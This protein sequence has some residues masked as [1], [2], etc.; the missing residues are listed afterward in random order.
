MIRWLKPPVGLA[1]LA[2][3]VALV[4]WSGVAIV[5]AATHAGGGIALNNLG[6]LVLGL[7]SLGASADCFGWMPP[8]RDD[9]KEPIAMSLWADR[10]EIERAG[11]IDQAPRGS[12]KADPSKE[13]IYLGSF[14]DQQGALELRYHGGKSLM[15]FGTPGANKSAGLVAPSISALRRSEAIIDV[16]GE[17]YNITYRQR[18]LMGTVLRLDPFGICDDAGGERFHWNPILQVDPE[19][20]D[21]ASAAYCIADAM[22]DKGSGG[23]NS[24]FFENSALNL[25]AVAVM[26]ERYTKGDKASLRNVRAMIA[27]PNRYDNNKQLVGGFLYTLKQMAE[28]EHPAIR[29]AGAR[30]Y[31]RLT[32]QNS[33]ATSAQ[34]VIDTFMTST[35]F[36]DDPRI[37]ADMWQGEAIDFAKLHEEI[38]TIYLV[39]PPHQLAAQAKWL[40]L[41]VNLALAELYRNPPS[42][43]TL[44]SVLFLLDEFGNLGSLSEI[45]TALNLS[46]GYRIQLWLFLQ[47]L[48][49]LKGNYKDKWG[50]FF[51]GAGAITSFRTGDM[52]TAEQLA[53]FYGNKEQVVPTQTET[54][55]SDTPHAIP[56]IRP[57]DINRLGQGEMI[58]MI[59]P[60]KMPIKGI[61]PVYPQTRFNEG[62]DPNPYYHG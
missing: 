43:P 58:S 10:A 62:L 31:A 27:E 3:G 55:V 32:D 39:L 13:G 21:F 41:F 9:E 45:E 2:L 20:H 8:M 47:N 26:W 6:V 53:K 4:W 40:R 57:E 25:G 11:V 49:Q 42:K 56:L 38:T 7:V 18:L 28:C 44:P 30:L 22:N 37:G 24:K 36:L 35:R 5:L 1:C 51:S 34:D 48:G 12:A 33:Q 54:S 52:E 17:L 14:V 19:S 15:T 23:G 61:A 60:C 29:N 50:A 46:R 16:K 59:E